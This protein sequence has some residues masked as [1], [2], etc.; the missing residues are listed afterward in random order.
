LT[1]YEYYNWSALIDDSSREQCARDIKST[2][3]QGKFWDNSPPYQTNIN[4]FTLPGQHW[5]NL[6][7]SFIWSCFAYMQ[8]EVQI[9]AVKSWG[10]MTSLQRAENRDILWHNHIRPDAQVLSGVFYL[11]M[12][13]NINLDTAGTEFAPNGANDPDSFHFAPAKIGHWIIWPGKEWHRPGI[14]QSQKD[15]FIVAADMEY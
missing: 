5:T 12:P 9:R 3:S 4:I 7:M 11:Y 8:R 15:R 14:L 13:P 10:Y 6:K 2:V 1:N